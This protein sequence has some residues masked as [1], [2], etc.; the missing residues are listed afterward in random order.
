MRKTNEE[1]LAN[2]RQQKQQLTQLEKDLIKQVKAEERKAD[3]RRKIII[4]G[5][6]LKY[7]EKWK[8]LDPG[9]ESDFKEVERVMRNVANDAEIKALLDNLP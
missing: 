5:I 6:A 4:G 7:F 2:V 8:T 1:K 9:V 3:T